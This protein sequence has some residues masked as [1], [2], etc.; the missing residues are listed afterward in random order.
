MTGT[1]T[2]RTTRLAMLCVAL[3]VVALAGCNRATLRIPGAST[4]LAPQSIRH[5]ARHSIGRPVVV[6]MPSD[7]RAQH[8]GR[9][10]AGT[11]WTACTTDSLTPEQ[12]TLVVQRQLETALRDS[13]VFLSV[14]PQSTSAREMTL[15]TEVMALCSQVRGFL[16]ARGAGIAALRL[17]LKD[18][19]RTVFQRTISRVVTDDQP[20]YSGAQVTTVE[21][22]MRTLM[23]DSLREISRQLV[24]QLDEAAP[25]LK[26]DP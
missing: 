17:S 13:K 1:T 16:I 7:N 4:E 6:A 22:V 12:A 8:L 9:S 3:C 24:L 21:Q 15:E 11:D 25:T 23:S 20:E 10:I 2:S 19:A 14:A 26:I 5:T 18:G